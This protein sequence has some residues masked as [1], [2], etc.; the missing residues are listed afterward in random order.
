MWKPSAL[1]LCP[2]DYLKSTGCKLPD[3]PADNC[4]QLGGLAS[5]EGAR[6][7]D[8]DDPWFFSSLRVPYYRFYCL[9]SSEFCKR[10]WFRKYGGLLNSEGRD[11]H[12]SGNKSRGVHHPEF[13]RVGFSAAEVSLE[14]EETAPRDL[15][16]NFELNSEL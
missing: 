3:P 14:R 1:R 12:H 7:S 9:D 16:V 8:I 2:L 15:F 13:A 6:A 5:Q 4:A 11:R 10:R